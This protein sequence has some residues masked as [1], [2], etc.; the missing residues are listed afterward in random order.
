M[1]GLHP[2][3]HYNAVEAEMAV[4]RKTSIPYIE[5]SGI[6]PSGL[7]TLLTSHS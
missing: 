7:P 5:R 6:S 3:P 2:L 1:K 4:Y